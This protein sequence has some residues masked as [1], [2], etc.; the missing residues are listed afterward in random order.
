MEKGG[1]VDHIFFCIM[2]VRCL[3]G[4]QMAPGCI[5][6]RVQV[7]V[8]L[9]AV[10]CVDGFHVN[11]TFVCVS[12]LNTVCTCSVDHIQPFMT[13]KFLNGSGF[14][15]QDN[16]PCHTSKMGTYTMLWTCK[17]GF[18]VGR[19]KKK[20]KLN[21]IKMDNAITKFINPELVSKTFNLEFCVCACV[22]VYVCECV[23]HST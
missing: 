8:I 18:S 1:Q 16:V 3:P 23:G 20:N 12:Y 10:I 15:Q 6:G 2:W 17:S 14:L 19:K 21:A 11:V 9:R 4:G 5:V 13:T 7:C 22:C